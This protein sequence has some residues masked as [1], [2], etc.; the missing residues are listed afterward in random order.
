MTTV[1]EVEAALRREAGE[2]L[3]G[4]GLRAALERF[5]TPRVHGSYA[6][7]LMTWRDLDVYLVNDAHT[8]AAWFALGGA[9]AAALEPVK[10]SFRNEHRARTP[11]LP[12]GLYWG[13]YLGDERRGAWKVDVWGVDED[14]HARLSAREAAL[15]ARLAPE[16]RAA[17][18]ALKSAVWSDPEYRRS[19]TSRDVYD[20]V[21]DHG[22]RTP[23]EL[24]VHLARRG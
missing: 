15:A 22:I 13:V 7:G 11:H 24:R 16:T 14:E 21:L 19:F 5:G 6:L 17:I 2:L 9:L 12:R 23:G 3:D 4:R 18:L 8:E 1:H 10:M 20:A